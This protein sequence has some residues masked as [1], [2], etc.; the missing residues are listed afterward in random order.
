MPWWIRAYLG[1]LLFYYGV[2]G[3]RG[4]PSN[5]FPLVYSFLPI[6]NFSS[7]WVPRRQ[8][9]LPL[10]LLLH[11][12]SSRGL[13]MQKH[14][15]NDWLVDLLHS[16]TSLSAWSKLPLVECFCEWTLDFMLYSP[17]SI[18]CSL[19][20]KFSWLPGFFFLSELLAEHSHA[21]SHRYYL[22][23]LLCCSGRGE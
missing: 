20:A 6:M 11:S 3:L 14:S 1:T 10:L 5:N 16:S 22:G 15:T 8:D 19:L 18:Y 2:T 9:F 17:E 4:H 21:R 7:V 23:L 12:V 13:D